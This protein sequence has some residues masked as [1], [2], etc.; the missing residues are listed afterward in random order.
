[1]VGR[2]RDWAAAVISNTSVSRSYSLWTCI[3]V[4]VC[5][6]GPGDPCTPP[7]L[8]PAPLLSPF[9]DPTIIRV[10]PA[11]Q[12]LPVSVPVPLHVL[13]IPAVLSL[14]QPSPPPP[15]NQTKTNHPVHHHPHQPAAGPH[16]RPAHPRHHRVHRRRLRAL[17]PA[18]GGAAAGGAGSLVGERGGVFYDT[19][20]AGAAEVWVLSCG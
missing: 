6:C 13:L 19:G 1:L 8:S 20:G 3:R 15:P 10:R 4:Y 11:A 5:T 17:D 7:C 16:P 14:P 18:P 2:E 12:A 9:Q